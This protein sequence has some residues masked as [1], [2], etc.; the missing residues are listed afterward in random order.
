[1]YTADIRDTDAR[2]LTTGNILRLDCKEDNLEG[3]LEVGIKNARIV[4]YWRR[5]VQANIGSVIVSV[6]ARGAF[7]AILMVAYLRKNSVR[8]KKRSF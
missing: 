3:K 6:G 7:Q 5:A 8:T 1:M 2:L 4:E